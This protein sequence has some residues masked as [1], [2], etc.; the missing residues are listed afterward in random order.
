MEKMIDI[1][2]AKLNAML[3]SNKIS[4]D[5]WSEK[6]EALLTL[7]SYHTVEMKRTKKA[8]SN[9][10]TFPPKDNHHV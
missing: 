1:Q 2:I 4:V 6:V 8:K 9:R 3:S 7:L 10:L 5:S